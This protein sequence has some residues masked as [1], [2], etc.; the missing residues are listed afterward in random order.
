M[1]ASFLLLM[2]MFGSSVFSQE[3]FRLHISFTGTPGDSVKLVYNKKVVVVPTSGNEAF[4]E[5]ETTGPGQASLSIPGSNCLVGFYLEPGNIEIR[6]EV[7]TIDEGKIC[8]RKKEV[9]GSN[10][11][12]LMKKFNDDIQKTRRKYE[13]AFASRK[14]KEMAID[15]IKKNPSKSFSTDIV[16]SLHRELGNEWALE[17]LELIDDEAKGNAVSYVNKA[18]MSSALLQKGNIIDFTQ[19]SIEDSFTLSGLRGKY[20]LLDFWASWCL[21]CRKENPSLVKLYEKHH[22][23]GFEI[24]GISLDHDRE[25]WEEAIEKDGLPWIHVSDL[26]GWQNNVSSTLGINSIPSAILLDKEGRII[27]YDLRGNDLERA[28]ERLFNKKD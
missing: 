1:R 16:M 7:F 20:V 2:M 4:I 9:K 6:A 24:V 19:P 25:K 3:P 13:P 14:I 23:L 11:E 8:I 17:A 26:K 5:G 22:D 21:P 28:V 10:A 12:A 15:I 18:M 27:D